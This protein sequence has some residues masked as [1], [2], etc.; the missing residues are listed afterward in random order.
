MLV[1]VSSSP[2]PLSVVL[3]SIHP[4]ATKT[5]HTL[6][7]QIW[8]AD[9]L[10]LLPARLPTAILQNMHPLPS[11]QYLGISISIVSSIPSDIPLR[12][13]LQRLDTVLSSPR[14]SSLLSVYIRTSF[15]GPDRSLN[16][17]SWRSMS[18]TLMPRL[19]QK[20]LPFK[21]VCF[22]E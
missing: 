3:A 19:S 8:I 18:Q 9:E 5:I 7:F 6:C 4:D 12:E 2:F 11:L 14:Y 15:F 10:S 1:A 13:D 22:S 17:Q 16:L 21:F 20:P